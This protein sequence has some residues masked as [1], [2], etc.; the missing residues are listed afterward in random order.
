MYRYWP[1]IGFADMDYPYQYK[2]LVLTDMNAHI[3][4]LT[5]ILKSNFL[6]KRLYFK[7]ILIL[8]VKKKHQM[9]VCKSIPQVPIFFISRKNNFLFHFL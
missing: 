4:S 2:L 6:N 7:N 3:G 9:W 1:I 8:K 5:D